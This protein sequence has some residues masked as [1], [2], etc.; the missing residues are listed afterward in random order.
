MS[1]DRQICQHAFGVGGSTLCKC[2]TWWHSRCWWSTQQNESSLLFCERNDFFEQEKNC[3]PELNS[4][5]QAWNRHPTCTLLLSC[6]LPAAQ[7]QIGFAEC[8]MSTLHGEMLCK[9]VLHFIGHSWCTTQIRKSRTLCWVCILSRF[10][11]PIN[12]VQWDL[13]GFLVMSVL[14]KLCPLIDR[15]EHRVMGENKAS[16]CILSSKPGH[17]RSVVSCCFPCKMSC[18][19][20]GGTGSTLTCP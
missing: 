20:G 19:H 17:V 14:S 18:L 1:N 16:G 15:I 12:S 6:I 10:L 5:L 8:P 4:A 13:V 3:K 11:L 7:H 9:W 2:L